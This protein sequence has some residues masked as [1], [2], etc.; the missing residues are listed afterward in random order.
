MELAAALRTLAAGL[1]TDEKV[2]FRRW[3]KQDKL[4]SPAAEVHEVS[5]IAC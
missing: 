1:T 4:V 3:L 2:A 5:R